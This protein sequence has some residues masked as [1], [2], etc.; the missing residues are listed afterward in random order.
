M[1]E[2][3]AG[4]N[5]KNAYA[6]RLM[7]NYRPPYNPNYCRVNQMWG[8][9]F[10]C[11]HFIAEPFFLILMIV[12]GVSAAEIVFST[13]KIILS[14]SFSLENAMESA[15]QILPLLQNEL[16]VTGNRFYKTNA[17][18]RTMSNT[19]AEIRAITILINLLNQIAGFI[20]LPASFLTGNTAVF[21]NTMLIRH[22]ESMSAL[23]KTFKQMFEGFTTLVT[24]EGMGK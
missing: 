2:I 24:A 5:I 1:D 20:L 9:L 13:A 21:A 23:I 15:M 12:H 6:K 4:L 14:M 19:L 10:I 11:L 18:L 22:W 17:T 3:I 8:Y 16:L 7:E